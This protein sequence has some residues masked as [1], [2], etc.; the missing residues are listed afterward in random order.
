[1]IRNAYLLLFP[2]M[3]WLAACA[4]V[5]PTHD[6]TPVVMV[7]NTVAVTET[8][9]PPTNT[10]IP[11][12]TPTPIVTPTETQTPT[13]TATPSPTPGPPLIFWYQDNGEIY[14]YDFQTWASKKI[15]LSSTG[16]VA[17]AK[18]SP[19]SQWIAY[20]DEEGLKYSRFPQGESILLTEES[21]IIAVENF[22]F[23]PDSQYLAYMSEMG[24]HI[25]DLSNNAH[26]LLWE[27]LMFRTSANER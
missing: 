8:A 6:P 24:L 18:I 26:S 21:K 3:L 14:Q 15:L 10:P 7:M 12:S 23:S 25:A 13:P 4:N 1:M 2:I 9:V 20:Y 11:T 27:R 22:V 5:T 17:E 19:N 16:S